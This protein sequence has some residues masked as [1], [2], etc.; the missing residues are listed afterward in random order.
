[1]ARSTVYVYFANRDELL[2]ACLQRMHAQLLDGHGRHVGGGR[3][4]RPPARAPGRGDAGPGRR[5]PGVLPAG[6][7]HPGPVTAGGE[8]VGTELALIGLDIARLI[9]DLFVDGVAR[10]EFR[11]STRTW[12]P[13]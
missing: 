6:P 1:M 2:R 10:G 4:A 5:Q 11:P 7:R 13:P 8:A 3:R 12:P 9:Q